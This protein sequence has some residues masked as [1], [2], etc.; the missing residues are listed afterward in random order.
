MVRGLK[1]IVAAQSLIIIGLGVYIYTLPENEPNRVT[2]Q[3]LVSSTKTFDDTT[4]QARGAMVNEEKLLGSKEL[5]PDEDASEKKLLMETTDATDRLL[6]QLEGIDTVNLENY[7]SENE[8]MLFQAVHKKPELVAKFLEQFDLAQNINFES[9][10]LLAQLIASSDAEDLEAHAL[11][12]LQQSSGLEKRKWIH[13]LAYVG[14][15][16]SGTRSAVLIGMQ[17]TEDPDQLR[18]SIDSLAPYDTNSSERAEVITTLT[19]L[20][21]HEDVNVRASAVTSMSYWSRDPESISNSLE[22]DSSIVRIAAIEAVSQSEVRSETL[23]LQLYS[24]MNDD[25]QPMEHR[26]KAANALQAYDL[27]DSMFDS[28]SNFL[29]NLSN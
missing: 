25:S 8:E 28:L 17:S 27:P 10:K 15:K 11:D 22:D 18:L 14:A 5:Q 2:S 4:P 21:T 23:Q 26:I 29:S 20:S 6:N 13:L 16:T 7:L 9:E 1:I 12:K 19:N 24:I 3:P